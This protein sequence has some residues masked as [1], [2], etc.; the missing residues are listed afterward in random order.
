[1]KRIIR[2]LILAILVGG[3]A[4][5]WYTSSRPVPL[6]LTGIVTTN[7]VVVSPQIAGRIEQ[8]SV[9]E[10]DQVKADQMIG[11]LDAGELEQEQAYY[12]AGAEGAS[13]Q[14]AESAAALRFQ[15]RQT[16]DQIR[17]AEA[18]L[19]AAQAQQMAA[20]AELENAKVGFSRA[21]QMSKQS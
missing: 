13:S 6:V 8:L 7:D 4:Y 21:E 18:N 17:Q 12:T 2:P 14:V 3:G 1:M 16:T 5:Y 11:V 15:E 9:D 10:G 20:Q 19:A